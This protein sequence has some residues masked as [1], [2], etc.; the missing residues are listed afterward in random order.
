MN[1]LAL[2]IILGIIV[3]TMANGSKVELWF[4]DTGMPLQKT[5]ELP[6][7]NPNSHILMGGVGCP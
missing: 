5:C 7:R 1:K 2:T 4:N 3:I 6:A